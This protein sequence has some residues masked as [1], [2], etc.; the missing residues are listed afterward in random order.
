[1]IKAMLLVGLGGG[2]GSMFRYSISVLF[3]KFSTTLFPWPTFIV[4][5]L[6]SFLMGL[7]ISYFG[8]SLVVSPNLKLLL[9]AGFCGGF[10]TFSTFSIEGLN[11]LNSG[12]T[13][14]ALTY[15]LGSVFFG[16]IAVWLGVTI[17][18]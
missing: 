2:V 5:V 3:N 7:L 13:T 1:M 6:G 16:L 9:V 14:I 10:T 15:I 11:L 4:N 12:N 17:G 18:K 8:R